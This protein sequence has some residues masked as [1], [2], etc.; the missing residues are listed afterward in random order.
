[1][2]S[3]NDDSMSKQKKR[4][5]RSKKKNTA[6]KDKAEMLINPDAKPISVNTLFTGFAPMQHGN[7]QVTIDH[8]VPE[9]F[10]SFLAT[11]VMSYH[12]S[13][14]LL[15]TTTGR[16]LNPKHSIRTLVAGLNLA[17][18][19]KL[20]HAAPRS[21]LAE[22]EEFAVFESLTVET[23][24]SFTE[25][26][27]LIG[28]TDHYDAVLRVKDN[29]SLIRTSFLKAVRAALKNP[30]FI[31]YAAL[32]LA[33]IN[34]LTPL[35]A[36][37]ETDIISVVFA[38]PDTSRKVQTLGRLRLS[39][40]L[41]ETIRLQVD[42]VA[43]SFS[44]PY[45]S[46]TSTKAQIIAWSPQVTERFQRD[47]LLLAAV[48]TVFQTSWMKHLDEPL[49]DIDH[50]F[51]GTD[52]ADITPNQILHA[53]GLYAIDEFFPDPA[54]FKHLVCQVVNY[55]TDHIPLF[56]C[57]FKIVDSG[58]SSFGSPAQLVQC[59]DDQL[60]R[61]RHHLLGNQ[62][63]TQVPVATSNVVTSSRKIDLP[64]KVALS[65]A[66]SLVRAVE[67]LPAFRGS[68][69]ITLK[70]ILGRTAR[71]ALVGRMDSPTDGV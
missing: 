33:A 65:A 66:I 6:N 40:L 45:I 14:R 69:T 43:H 56:K 31:D 64:D 10:A 71:K 16:P 48:L 5:P 8:T 55:W 68:T 38:L 70:E 34:R 57:M 24:S 67:W 25:I 15:N 22:L 44:P 13:H 42:G 53:S 59:P 36:F 21:Q 9:R 20:L 30:D 23:V 35:A 17:F 28:K 41:Q 61:Y 39:E 58:K 32:D 26:L 3:L 52:F 4:A 27:D 37:T 50:D 19:L 47:Q 1:M 46:G 7:V 60:E 54:D 49:S 62:F 29:P 18:G 2:S 12:S 63:T 51:V 11:H